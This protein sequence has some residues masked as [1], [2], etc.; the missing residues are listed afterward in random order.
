MDP[1]PPEGSSDALAPFVETLPDLHVP[2]EWVEA[3]RRIEGGAIRTVCVI[4]PADSGKS[5]LARFLFTAAARAGLKA[6]LIDTDL[7]QKTVGPPACVTMCDANGPS[8]A[9]VGTTDPVL[10]WKPLLDGVHRLLARTDAAIRI[11]NT[12]GLVSGPGRRLK[13]AKL[14]A[15]RPDLLI[16]LGAVPDIGALTGEHPDIAILHLP[17]SPCAR[18]KTDGERRTLRREAFRGYFRHASAVVLDRRLAPDLQAGSPTLGLLLGLSDA[19]GRDLGLGI[20]AEGEAGGPLRILT[21]VVE[22]PIHRITPGS[23]CLDEHFS[24]IRRRAGKGS[25]N[26]CALPGAAKQCG[27]PKTR[28]DPP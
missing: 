22:T 21:P 28:D 18:R 25:K 16:V 7:G 10:G 24:E 17:S 1:A 20:L 23:L 15:I 27:R 9:F 12:S 6:A 14:E 2:S 19:Q 4:G 13:A 3:A 26:E 8:L 11:V 5:T